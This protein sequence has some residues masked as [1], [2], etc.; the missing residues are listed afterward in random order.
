MGKTINVRNSQSVRQ[1][2][3]ALTPEARESRIVAKAMDM[4]EEM[5]DNRT[6]SSQLLTIFI[7]AGMVRAEIELEELKYKNEL[8]RAKTK[9]IESNDNNETLYNQVIKEL[10][11]YRGEDDD[12]DY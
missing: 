3:P 6:A 12:Y 10:R 1:E 9:S 7:K 8:T 4:A 11:S 2:P 5:I